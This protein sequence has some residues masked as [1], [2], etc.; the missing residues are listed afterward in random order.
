MQLAYPDH[1][2]VAVVDDSA[3]GFRYSHL[4]IFVHEPSAMQIETAVR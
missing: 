3:F 2:I 1:K 4:S